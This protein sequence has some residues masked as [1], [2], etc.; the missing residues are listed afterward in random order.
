L[1]VQPLWMMMDHC[2][3]LQLEFELELHEASLLPSP[4]L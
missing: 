1:E 3:F 4:S 2:F